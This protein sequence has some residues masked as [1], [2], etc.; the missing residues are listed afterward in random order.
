SE[1]TR[2]LA[3]LTSA[4]VC[5]LPFK[6][7]ALAHTH[8]PAPHVR[9]HVDTDLLVAARDVPILEEVLARLGYIRPPETSGRLVSYQSHYR[10]TDH[11]G[12]IHPVDVHWKISNMQ[13]LADRFTFEEL[14]ESRAPVPALC[15]ST[16]TIDAVHA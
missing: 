12:V 2:V 5:V 6:G 4:G 3:E 9:V 13:S 15:S 10:R 1:L 14:W 11:H 7:A 16:V 8:Y